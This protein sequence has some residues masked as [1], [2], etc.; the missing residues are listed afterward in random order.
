[1]SLCAYAFSIIQII[2]DRQ[3]HANTSFLLSFHAP[4]LEEDRRTLS[5]GMLARKENLLVSQVSSIKFMLDLLGNGRCNSSSR[6]ALCLD[7]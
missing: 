4:L 7:P 6:L 2:I 3:E 1:M 5:C